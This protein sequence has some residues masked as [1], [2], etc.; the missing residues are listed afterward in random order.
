MSSEWEEGHSYST[1]QDG[2]VA[3]D[4]MQCFYPSALPAPLCWCADQYQD[5]DP[6]SCSLLLHSLWHRIR[7][8]CAQWASAC[9]LGHII[10]IAVRSLLPHRH[11]HVHR[12]GVFL[13][14]MVPWEPDMLYWVP[15]RSERFVKNFPAHCMH[16]L[17]EQLAKLLRFPWRWGG[18]G[19]I[20]WG[21]VLPYLQSLSQS[22][23]L[24]TWHH[25]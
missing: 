21:S 2:R 8:T 5:S 20:D 22:I 18:V 19:S 6:R 16:V 3:V 25:E 12:E 14:F 24:L 15:V 10:L 9:L 7:K 17:V 1:H 11:Q 23:F 4:T 13:F